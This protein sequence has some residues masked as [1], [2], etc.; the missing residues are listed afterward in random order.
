MLKLI[1]KYY[2]I[3]LIGCDRMKL[4][5]RKGFTLVELLATIVILGV[6]AAIAMVSIDRV[7]DNSQIT[8]CENI[9]LSIKSAT[10]E[11]I[12]DHR[13]DLSG[14]SITMNVNDLVVGGFLSEPITNPFDK[15]KYYKNDQKLEDLKIYITL[16]ADYTYQ[17][18][19]IKASN[20]IITCSEDVKDGYV[21]FPG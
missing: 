2:I 10:K 9:L 3:T 6:I 11:Y 14:K 17:S 19:E 16:N 20:K 18:A 21:R 5:N 4:L 8:E 1:N 15:T 7:L 13:F 12:S